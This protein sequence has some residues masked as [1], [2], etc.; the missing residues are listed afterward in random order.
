M[1]YALRLYDDIIDGD[2]LEKI[3]YNERLQISNQEK[4]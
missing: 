3:N 1:Y 2:T 4:Y